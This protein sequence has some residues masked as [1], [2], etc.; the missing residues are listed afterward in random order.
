MKHVPFHLP[1]N[2]HSY[3]VENN[4]LIRCLNM[5]PNSILQDRRPAL[6]PAD[7]KLDEEDIQ[8]VKLRTGNDIPFVPA[9]LDNPVT[10]TNAQHSERAS[11]TDLNGNGKEKASTSAEDYQLVSVIEE[12]QVDEGHSPKSAEK[13]NA[14][15]RQEM[16]DK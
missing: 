15:E 16:K 5:S 2:E 8:S 1:T 14:N 7:A 9:E 13:C 6:I 3:V 4:F 12:M 10:S 11:K